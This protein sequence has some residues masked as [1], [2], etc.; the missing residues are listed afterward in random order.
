MK[1]GEY[2][3]RKNILSGLVVV[4]LGLTPMVAAAPSFAATTTPTHTNFFQGL[5]TFLEQKF[6]LDKTQ[7][8]AAI[9]DYKNQNKGNMQTNMQN[10]EKTY[11]D[12]LVSQGKLTSSQEAAILAELASLQST[13]KPTTGETSA[14]RMQQMQ[15][16]QADLKTW[17]AQQNPPI[18][19]TLIMPMGGGPRGGFRHGGKWGMHPST[20]PTPTQ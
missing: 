16:M 8:T 3:I 5:I 15:Q 11:L 2:M 20:T 4:L 10:R 14:Q 6:G 19:V 18:D 9:T 13:Y 12:G 1:G 17:A 7:V